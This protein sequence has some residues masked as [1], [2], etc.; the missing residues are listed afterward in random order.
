[1]GHQ[2]TISIIKSRTATRNALLLAVAANAI[3]AFTSYGAILISDG[4]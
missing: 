3:F 4:K 2:N 1:V